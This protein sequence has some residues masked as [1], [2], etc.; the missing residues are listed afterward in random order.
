MVET[1]NG[2]S[3]L[4]E[5]LNKK[6][7][8]LNSIISTANSKLA[9]LNLGAEVWLLREPIQVGDF[10]DTYDDECEH[11]IDRWR[12]ATILGYSKVDDEWELSVKEV[13]F[14]TQFNPP[15]NDYEEVVNPKEPVSLLQASREVRINAMRVLPTLLDRLEKAANLLL[16][17]IQK[18]EETAAKL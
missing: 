4:S 14:Q 3:R 12:S 18:A 2:L 6:S 1:I 5:K 8:Q 7:N 11:R 15:G 17:S 16:E 13:T 9:K 10:H